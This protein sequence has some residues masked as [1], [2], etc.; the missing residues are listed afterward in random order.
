MESI[1][2]VVCGTKAI[3]VSRSRVSGVGQVSVDDSLRST[4][5]ANIVVPATIAVSAL[6]GCMSTQLRAVAVLSPSIITV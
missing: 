5:T 3:P 6:I 4:D 2:D 1:R